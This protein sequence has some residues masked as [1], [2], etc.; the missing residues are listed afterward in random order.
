MRQASFTACVRW[1]NGDV[2]YK[3]RKRQ[4]GGNM[5]G[6][7]KRERSRQDKKGIIKLAWDVIV[8]YDWPFVPEYRFDS[9][10]RWRF[11]WACV[12]SKIAIEIEGITHYGASIGRHQSASGIEGD[13][14]KYNRAIEL[15]WKVLR[16]SQ[17]MVTRDPSG[18][19]EQIKRVLDTEI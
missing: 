4:D 2:L 15:G 17:R 8:G 14:E 11:D 19:V 12:D 13:M 18:C 16:Y 3:H 1:C 10:R 6:R 7:I 9:S 5:P